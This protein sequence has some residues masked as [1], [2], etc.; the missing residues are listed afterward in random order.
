[1]KGIELAK[2]SALSVQYAFKQAVLLAK[3]GKLGGLK[4]L[5]FRF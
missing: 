4:S 1:M 3:H 2:T 5:Q